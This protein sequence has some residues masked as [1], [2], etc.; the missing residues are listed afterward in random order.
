MKMEYPN[1]KEIEEADYETLY[2]WVLFLPLPYTMKVKEGRKWIKKIIPNDNSQPILD[3]IRE[4][5][6]ELGGPNHKV[7]HRL[8]QEYIAGSEQE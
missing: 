1:L 3:R 8:F 2:G 5:W 7:A 6:Q 4:R